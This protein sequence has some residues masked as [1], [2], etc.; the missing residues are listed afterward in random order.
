M[1]AASSRAPALAGQ[2]LPRN[3][4]RSEL[5]RPLAFRR[6]LAAARVRHSGAGLEARGARV[7][8]IPVYKWDLPEDTGPL[9]ANVLALAEGH[10]MADAK[11]HFEAAMSIYEKNIHESPVD[12]ETM[13]LN[14]VGFL[15][16]TGNE[17]G[18]V[19]VAKR[20]AK[21]LKKLIGK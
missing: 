5:A 11:Q 14:Y 13:A 17:K 1:N 20:S 8:S 6:G 10:S 18:A 21:K 9:R 16:A 15:K 2:H 19:Q 4:G 12:F 7:L 3:A